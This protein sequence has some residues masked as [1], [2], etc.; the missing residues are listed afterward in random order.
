MTRHEATWAERARRKQMA[1]G[2]KTWAYGVTTVDSRLDTTLPLSLTTLADA[3]F[4]NPRL[5]VDGAQSVPAYLSK[6]EI[7]YR[8]PKIKTFGNWVLAL[9]ELYLRDPKATY[10]ALFQDDII[11]CKNLR[12]YLEK[13]KFP[14]RG[15][16]NLYTFPQNEQPE[17]GWHLSNQRG[18]GALALILNNEGVRTVLH[19][20]HTVNRPLDLKRGWKSID[21]GIVTA[22]NQ[23]GWKEYIHIP[24]LVQHQD[25]PSSMSN[26]QHPK[27]GTFPG[28]D[29]DALELLNS[30]KPEV[31]FSVNRVEKLG[32]V[33]YSCDTGLGELN[34]QLAA[35]VQLDYWLVKVHPKM[36]TNKVELSKHTV[37]SDGAKIPELL[38]HADTILFCEQPYYENLIPLAKAANKRIVCVPM[39]EWMPPGAK[40][41][42][43]KVDLFICPTEQCYRIFKN[44]VPCIYFPWPVDTER[45]VYQ[46]RTVCNRFL[47]LNG[48]GGFNGRKGAQ[49]IKQAKQLWPEMPL[50]VRSQTNEQW[51]TGTEVAY[52]ELSNE[53][54]YRIGDV[55]IAPHSVDGIGLE[56]MEAMSCG[57]PVISTD[58]EPWNE[59]PAIGKI[60]ARKEQRKV[61]RPVDWYLP[62]P[63]DLVRVCKSLV[64]ADIREQSQQAREW[65]E[66]RSWS[67]LA[68]VESFSNI[69]RGLKGVGS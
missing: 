3:G 46:P 2:A 13:C 35:Y 62:D 57:M 21:G 17:I 29:F 56:L 27:A 53:D 7:T 24:S 49:V 36:A 20:M 38:K 32:L 4:P 15:Y 69:V 60:Q 33:G 54:L 61:R 66:S 12:Q 39:M 30:V 1:L 19:S 58:G 18:L 43:E 9:A 52:P 23:A 45:F 14:E 26:R 55:L 48:H 37:C 64:G 44:N 63:A 28:V 65:A 47:F 10:Y 59:F 25:G 50:I 22:F 40:G 51:P 34:R 5:F 16:L 42:A 6:Y 31:T 67:N 8:Y 11:A 68:T 41:W